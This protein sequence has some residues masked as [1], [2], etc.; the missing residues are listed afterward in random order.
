MFAARTD[1]DL[2]PT[3]L[4][5]ALARRRAAGLPVLDLTESNP[6]RCGLLGGAE[7]I[8]GALAHPGN[9]WYEPAPLGRPEARAAV[10]RYYGDK[11]VALAAD[12]VCLTA[13]TSEAYAFLFRLLADPGDEV[14][15]P[16]PSYPLLDFLAGLNDVRLVP[17]PL[18]Y[19]RHWRVDLDALRDAVGP[20]ARAIVAVHPNNPTGSFIRPGERDAL[21]EVC[22]DHG[23]A[24]IVDE[25]FG[26]YAFEPTGDCAATLAGTAGALTFVLNGLSTVAALPQMKLAWIAA[27]GPEDLVRPALDRLEVIADTYLS[28][29]TPI[30]RALPPILAARADIQQ[31]VLARLRAN[32]KTLADRLAEGGPAEALHAKGG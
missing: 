1:W 31:K 28:V 5:A 26:D 8:L 16:R 10:G 9:L 25:V 19:D 17:Y 13:S 22:R 20:R 2:T 7:G 30:Q 15:I 12:R 6:S 29:G 23:I 27:S 14:L 18:V 11:G 3:R 21:V 32:R 4:A 24:L